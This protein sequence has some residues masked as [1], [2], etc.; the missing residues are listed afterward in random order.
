MHIKIYADGGLVG[1]SPSTIGGAYAWVIREGGVILNRHGQ[2]I[3][4][5]ECVLHKFINPYH[6]STGPAMSCNY[7]ETAA[8]VNAVLNLPVVQGEVT[9][10]IVSDSANALN[11]A[12]LSTNMGDWMKYENLA[13]E[14]QEC[15]MI[16]SKFNVRRRL[17]KGHPSQSDLVRGYYQKEG[18]KVQKPVSKY[19]HWCHRVCEDICKQV[20]N[21]IAPADAVLNTSNL[22]CQKEASS[23]L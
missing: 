11:W 15:H 7:V 6:T 19:Q 1:A 3:D 22:F 8:I 21:G 12:T 10:T 17:V 2:F 9:L 4:A 23:G 13:L 14:V 16:L 20:K 18:S 5:E